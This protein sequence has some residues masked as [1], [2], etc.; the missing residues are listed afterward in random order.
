MRFVVKVDSRSRVRIR[1]Q[2]VKNLH[3]NRKNAVYYLRCYHCPTDVIDQ[4]DC[5]AKRLYKVHS[6]LVMYLS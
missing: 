5:M 2:T 6:V 4:M 3:P 1:A